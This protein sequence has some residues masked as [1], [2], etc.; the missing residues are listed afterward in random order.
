MSHTLKTKFKGVRFQ[1]KAVGRALERMGYVHGKDFFFSEN[2]D[3]HL[4]DYANHRRTN[5][6]P[7]QMWIDRNS[8]KSAANPNH[9]AGGSNEIGFRAGPNGELVLVNNKYDSGNTFTPAVV[10]EFTQLVK[11]EMTKAEAIKRGHKKFVE[12]RKK[13]KIRLY[14]Q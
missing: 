2:C 13:G 6:E 9:V 10:R 14:V 7:V 5:E 11:I 1:L 3:H 12:V 4:V 8:V